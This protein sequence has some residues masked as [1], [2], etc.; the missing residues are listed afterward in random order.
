MSTLVALFHNRWSVPILAE[1]HR[2][3]GSR[4]V[5]LSRTLG[6]SRESLRRTLVALIDGGLVGRNPGYGHPLRPEY[7]LTSAGEGIAGACRPLV[8]QLRRGN[9]EQIGLK[10]WS[11]PV[12]FAL[13]GGP[14]RFSELREQLE[15][16]SPRALALALKDL[17]EA[18]IVDR[19]VTEDYPPAA[20]YRLTKRGRPLAL[21]VRAIPASS[22]RS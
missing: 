19:R 6:L 8:D 2:Q 18:G 1:L 12:V 21:L 7:V 16:V 10:K 17:E 15:G 11:M 22:T 20:M 3:R 5:T 13:A 14:L 9:L 4:F